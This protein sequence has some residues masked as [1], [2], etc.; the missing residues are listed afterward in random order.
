MTGEK[1]I[2]ANISNLLE[3]VLQQQQSSQHAINVEFCE[4]IPIPCEKE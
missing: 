3:L 1:F 4:T 2:L